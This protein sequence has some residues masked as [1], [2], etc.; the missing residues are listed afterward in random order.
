MKNVKWTL[1]LVIVALLWASFQKKEDVQKEL[2]VSENEI[3]PPVPSKSNRQPASAAAKGATPQPTALSGAHGSS[4]SQPVVAAMNP[5][6][7]LRRLKECLQSETCSYPQIDPQSYALGV[8]QD[9]KSVLKS[10][11]SLVS[12]DPSMQQEA[13]E[14]AREFM[15]SYDGH[16][17]EGALAVF[18]VLPPSSEN[19]QAIVEG[20]KA[21]AADPLI[22]EQAA[23]ELS[24]Y[25]NSPAEPLVHQFFAETLSQGALFTSQK[26]GVVVKD[27]LTPQSVSQYR[28][29]LKSMRPDSTAARNLRS[30]LDEYDRRRSGG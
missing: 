7:E 14:A 17:Q 26:A 28:Q 11:A 16:I 5:M 1:P 4:P 3:S 15:K 20:L 2:M 19:L 18:A 6:Q 23:K 10:L 8:G 21:N 30:T 24:R 27:V 13:G 9:L 12:A 29:V 25:V 22:L